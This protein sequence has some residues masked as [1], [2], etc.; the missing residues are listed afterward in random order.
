VSIFLFLSNKID[1]YALL[2]SNYI[3]ISSFLLL[4]NALAPFF[5]ESPI[6]LIFHFK[7]FNKKP[8]VLLLDGVEL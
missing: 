8:E 4:E 6:S 2:L 5:N 7:L 3:S 1:V